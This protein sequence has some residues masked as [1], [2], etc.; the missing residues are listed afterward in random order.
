M[1]VT[2][3]RAVLAV[4]A[5]GLT[6]IL[7]VAVGS[8]GAASNA[9]GADRFEAFGDGSVGSVQATPLGVSGAPQTYVVQLKDDPVA[10][11]QANQGRKLSPDEKKAVKDQLK[12]KQDALAGAISGAGGTVLADYQFAYNGI[13]VR[14]VPARRTTLAKLPDVVGVRRSRR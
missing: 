10:L 6:T 14:I 11:V 5:A 13:K 9:T 3:I 8:A 1:Y 12:G 2:R 4:F 7:L